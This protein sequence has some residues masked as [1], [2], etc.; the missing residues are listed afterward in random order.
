MRLQKSAQETI[1]NELVVR[2]SPS[3]SNTPDAAAG[4][5]D[6]SMT[7][8]DA[9]EAVEEKEPRGRRRSAGRGEGGL[10]GGSASI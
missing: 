2:P 7:Q 10:E 4:S 5:L 8:A 1:V 9:L 3:S 6:L